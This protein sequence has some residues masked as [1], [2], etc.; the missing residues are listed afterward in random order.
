MD[1]VATVLVRV[2]ALDKLTMIGNGRR[3]IQK[4][5]RVRG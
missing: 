3:D 2:I 5:E 1:E 4:L